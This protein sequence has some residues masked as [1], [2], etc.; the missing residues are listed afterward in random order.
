MNHIIEMKLLSVLIPM[1]GLCGGGPAVHFNRIRLSGRHDSWHPNI[2]A[3][4]K[5]LPVLSLPLRATISV[6]P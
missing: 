1:V 4:F 3:M 2:R 6:S 5:Q